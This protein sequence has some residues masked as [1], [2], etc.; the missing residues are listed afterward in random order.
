MSSRRKPTHLQTDFR[1]D[2]AR[3]RVPNAWNCHQPVDS[4]LKGRE[5]FA[6]ARLHVAHGEFECIDLGE[7][8]TQQEAMM[9][10][11]AAMQGSNDDAANLQRVG[12]D[13]FELTFEDVPD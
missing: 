2:D 1:D 10:G 3:H 9:R 8:Q 5:G 11:H 6:Q 7:M 13:E 12:Q 4:V